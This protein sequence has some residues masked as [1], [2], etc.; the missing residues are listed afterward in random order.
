M[1][2]RIRPPLRR[3]L[4]LALFGFGLVCN[5]QSESLLE[6]YQAAQGYDAS[7][8]AAQAQLDAIS[9]KAEQVQALY[10]PV[11]SLQSSLAQGWQQSK[12]STDTYDY[13]TQKN[14]LDGTLSLAFSQTLYSRINELS[15]TS[16][17]RNAAVVE[18]ALATARQD[19]M[20][21]VSS[22]YFDVL[23]ARDSL[24][25]V[26]AQKAAVGEQLSAA[27][28]NFEVG[29]S[30]ITDTREAQAKF[31]L[32]IAQEISAQNDLTVRQSLLDQLVGRKDLKPQSL[33][34]PLQL[35]AV[36]GTD[37]EWAALTE[38]YLPQIQSKRTELELARLETE[39]ARAD[40]SPTVSLT[41]SLGKT[42]P[43]GG[44][45]TAVDQTGVNTFTRSRDAQSGSVGLVLNIPLFTGSTRGAKLRET[46]ALE[47]KTRND[48]QAL[49]RNAQQTT[50]TVFY[51]LHSLAGQVKAY[52][53]AEASSQSALDANRL[54]Y[55]V[56]VRINIDVLNAQS[57]L[58]DTKAKLAKARYDV[59]VSNLKLRQAAG[60]LAESNLEEI[61]GLMAK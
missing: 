53:A 8:Q 36:L 39:K 33:R 61:D 57:Q 16:A 37:N 51:G 59:L 54:G 58:Y 28:R 6:M 47:D 9:A 13:N 38:Q 43:W 3:Q 44:S 26:R 19:L 29:T 1:T 2:S 17:Q 60:T 56:G 5:A 4:S 21:R 31:D 24:A 50:R 7:Y 41:G 18:L 40:T 15:M 46:L 12:S 55:E 25:F 35:P 20:V 23:A 49:T 48:L 27:K 34:L 45:N 52:E 10:A 42:F 30:T 11:V 22:A 14:E 32:V